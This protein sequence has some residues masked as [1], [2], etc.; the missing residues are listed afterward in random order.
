MSLFTEKTYT[1]WVRQFV[2]FYPAKPPRELGAVEATRFLTYLATDRKVSAFTQ[3]QALNAI[4]FLFKH[5]W[6]KDFDFDR[7][8]IVAQSELYNAL[9]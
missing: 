5:L 3:N 8:V 1:H 2:S 7:N 4:V 6:V 9:S